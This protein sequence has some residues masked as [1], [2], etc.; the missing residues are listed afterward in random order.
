M[1]KETFPVTLC[2]DIHVK[3]HHS[4]RSILPFISDKCTLFFLFP[5]DCTMM[6][7]YCV[8][9]QYS[10]H[11]CI[12]SC[13]KLNLVLVYCQPYKHNKTPGSPIKYLSVM[14]WVFTELHRD[15][16]EEEK[17]FVVLLPLE[18]DVELFPAKLLKINP[19]LLALRLIHSTLYSTSQHFSLISLNIK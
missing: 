7:I 16:Q 15:R 18:T 14:W 4:N 12:Y 10:H 13:M 11:C 3:K 8:Q 9:W 1:F 2:T 17:V 5:L 19:L 6:V